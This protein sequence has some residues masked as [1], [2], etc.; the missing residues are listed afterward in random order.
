MATE[1]AQVHRDATTYK[2][3][4][5]L[6]DGAGSIDRLFRIA[7]QET[8]ID[9]PDNQVS[10]KSSFAPIDEKRMDGG[11]ASRQPKNSP[12][13]R[14]T[15]QR[16]K[17]FAKPHIAD[18]QFD[19]RTDSASVQGG[20]IEPISSEASQM[21]TEVT[22]E[23]QVE[24]DTYYF[25]SSITD[26]HGYFE[27]LNNLR[28]RVVISSEFFRTRGDYK[29]FDAL[30][31]LYLIDKPSNVPTKT[32]ERCL[33]MMGNDQG[34]PQNET[35]KGEEGRGEL[36][37]LVKTYLIFSRIANS[38]DHLV[39]SPFS[40]DYFSLLLEH[41]G[42]DLAEIIRLPQKMIGTLKESLE[43]TLME[44]SCESIAPLLK[45]AEEHCSVILEL[46]GITN[47]GPTSTIR[48]SGLL[49]LCWMTAILLDLASV[50]YVGSHAGDLGLDIGNQIKVGVP[51]LFGFRCQLNPLA[52]L[53]TFV[54][55]GKVWTFRMV[56][57]GILEA[58]GDD[59]NKLLPPLSILTH[60]EE[61]ADLWGPVWSE[62]LSTEKPEKF[63]GH[64]LAKG[65]ILPVPN[66][67]HTFRNAKRC[68]YI[69]FN[70]TPSQEDAR[71][72]LQSENFFVQG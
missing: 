32:W 9:E 51:G 67:E 40:G 3:G 16:K 56:T 19:A 45:Q 65:Y 60:I 1:I 54:D 49:L 72:I 53:N 64:D 17:R 37:V 52:C 70:N 63:K 25:N 28:D 34:N 41:P 55:G 30:S 11:K 33:T 7:S 31:S 23:S 66:S 29:P 62:L 6:H 48:S 39:G 5:T 14:S 58:E 2:S 47:I 27:N 36:T 20:V 43:P 15:I 26:P 8:T 59:I 44:L 24:R 22:F 68:H 38:L 4:I 61:F 50:S 21:G 71:A 46:L 13:A 10:N 42:H 57:D 18:L 12:R 35:Y 69:S